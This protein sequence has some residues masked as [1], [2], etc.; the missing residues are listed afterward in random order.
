M[1]T[2]RS[3]TSSGAQAPMAAGAHVAV[4]E[5]LQPEAKVELLPAMLKSKVL[6][7]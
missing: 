4:S 2:K 3:E 5:Q 7:A 6:T 1:T